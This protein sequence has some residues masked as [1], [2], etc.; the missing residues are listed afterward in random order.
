MKLIFLLLL[1]LTFGV[2][3]KCSCQQRELD[4]VEFFKDARP[5]NVTIESYWSK[6]IKQRYKNNVV[7]SGRFIYNLS[8]SILINEQIGLQVR[9][10]FRRDYCYLPPL[11]LFL[12]K[13]PHP[14]CDH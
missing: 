8:D 3:Q 11:K 6:I 2:T 13:I 1:V 5:L 9:G 10:H 4:Q 7:F 14:F 12:R